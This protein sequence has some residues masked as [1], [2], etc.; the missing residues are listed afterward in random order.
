MM[1]VIN[2]VEFKVVY[3]AELG[4]N[5]AYVVGEGGALI[6]LTIEQVEHDFDVQVIF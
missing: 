1:L 4:V 2:W 3:N 6:D 5:Q